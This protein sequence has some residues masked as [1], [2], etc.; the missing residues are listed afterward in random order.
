MAVSPITVTGLTNGKVYSLALK[1]VNENGAGP[2][3]EEV[4]FTPYNTP[5]PLPVWLFA[6]L[7]ALIGGLGYRRLGIAKAPQLCSQA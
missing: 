3:S 4:L 1:A 6:L 7:S 2:P 5:V